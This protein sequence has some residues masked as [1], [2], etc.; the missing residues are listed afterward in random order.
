MRLLKTIGRLMDKI[1]PAI[2]IGLLIILPGI[3]G[4]MNVFI[5]KQYDTGLIAL[6]IMGAFIY[7]AV[8]AWQRKEI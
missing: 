3:A 8:K 5:Y 1:I 7:W 4:F 6:G 2:A